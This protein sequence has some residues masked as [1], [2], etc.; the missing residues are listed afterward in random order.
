[1]K[2]KKENKNEEYFK[3]H[4]FFINCKESTYIVSCSMERKLSFKEKL[5]LFFH[6]L[7]CKTCRLF[8]KQTI[9]LNEV[10]KKMSS[11]DSEAQNFKLSAQEKESMNVLIKKE[12]ES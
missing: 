9:L 8:K 12:M 6:L 2:E 4:G 3:G 7:I 11:A 1:M 10:F 5:G